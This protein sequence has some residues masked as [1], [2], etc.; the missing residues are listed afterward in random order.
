MYLLTL[1]L[2]KGSKFAIKIAVYRNYN[3]PVNKL[4]QNSN[5]ETQADNLV[6]FLQTVRP[7][8]GMTNEAIEIAFQQAN[9]EIN[10]AH[11]I[12]IG[13]AG[14]NTKVEVLEKRK[15]NYAELKTSRDFAQEMFYLDEL[16]RLVAKGVKVNAVYLKNGKSIIQQQQDI[17]NFQD[18]AE[19]GTGKYEYL[20]LDSKNSS[21]LLIDLITQQ[22]LFS[23]GGEDLVEK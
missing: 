16:N 1:I 23:I 5:W 3:A 22:V 12:L 7:E 4:I 11:V 19:N 18:I 10:L 8:Y 6:Q 15:K 14:A 21:Q 20:D 2:A 17:K 13:D 9:Q